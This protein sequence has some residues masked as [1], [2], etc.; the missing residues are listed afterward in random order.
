MS[1]EEKKPTTDEPQEKTPVKE[2]SMSKIADITVMKTKRLKEILGI[3]KIDKDLVGVVVWEEETT[4]SVVSWAE[5]RRL[6]PHDVLT[7]YEKFVYKC[8]PKC[9]HLIEATPQQ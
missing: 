8:I 3:S 1:Q 2:E 5:L 7:F 6:Y 9:S 4:P